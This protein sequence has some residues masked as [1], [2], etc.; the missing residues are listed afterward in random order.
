MNKG[1]IPCFTCGE[2]GHFIMDCPGRKGR[3]IILG[4]GPKVV[5]QCDI[6]QY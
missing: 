1:N 3:K 4:L 6:G 2:T 5:K